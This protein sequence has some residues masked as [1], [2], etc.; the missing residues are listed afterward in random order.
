MIK[1]LLLTSIFV[2]GGITGWMAA[3]APVSNNTYLI[4]EN[5]LFTYKNV[6]FA[7]DIEEDEEFFLIKGISK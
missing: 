6:G 4:R 7:H 2:V 1:I 5:K 3:A